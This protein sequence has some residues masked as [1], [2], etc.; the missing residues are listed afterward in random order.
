[1][2]S[3]ILLLAFVLPVSCF[4]QNLLVNGS[5]EME[6]ICTE[7]KINCAP[8]AWISN[9]S[10]FNNYYKDENRSFDGSHCMAIQ[11]GHSYK[12]YQR[13][14]LR[15]RLL[16]GLRKDGQYKLEFYIKSP[17]PVLDSIGV[18][19]GPR[20]PLLERKPI[21]LLS[22]SLRLID[23]GNQFKKDSSWQKA[24]LVYTAGGNEGYITIANFSIND[25]SGPTGLVKENNFFVYIDRISLAPLNPNER[26]CN[27]WEETKTDILEE[28]ERHEFLMRVIRHRQ[29]TPSYQRPAATPTTVFTTDTLMLPDLL[30]ATGKRDLKPSSQGVIDSFCAS[31][32]GKTIDSLVISGHTDNVG[33]DESN[34]QLSMDRAT[35]V[36]SYIVRCAAFFRVPVILKGEGSKKPIADNGTA[37]GRQKN[38]RV[39]LMVYFRE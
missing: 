18:Y 28:N 33:T 35:S 37:E 4:A 32:N 5:F 3:I 23:Q 1:M 38:R 27:D 17:H 30:F 11:V 16:C 14:F 13:T 8:E 20:D 26:L 2:K 36:D 10:G 6:N 7:Y 34:E 31:M 9:T 12:P 22:P 15:S 39:E 21:H 25:I 19:F 24:A 29:S